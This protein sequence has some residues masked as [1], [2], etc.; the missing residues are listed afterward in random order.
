MSFIN[1]EIGEFTAQVYHDGQFEEMSK[2]NVLGKWFV[3]FLFL[4]NRPVRV[5]I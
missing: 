5:V 3:F 1:K 2:K 4:K